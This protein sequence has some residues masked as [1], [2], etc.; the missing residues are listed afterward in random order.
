[1][2][3]AA[4]R[5]VEHMR[6]EAA[7]VSA[8]E[9]A[10]RLPVPRTADELARLATTLNSMLDRLQE[11]IERERRFVDNA[12]HELRTPLAT[13]RWSISVEGADL[14]AEGPALLVAPLRLRAPTEPVVLGAQAASRLI[15]RIGPRP[16]MSLGALVGAVGLFGLSRVT[17]HSG[18]ASGVLGPV[19]ALSF[20]LGL[21]FVS[22]TIVA[23]AGVS[24][25]ESGLSST[26]LNVGQQLG[27][28]LGIAVLGTIAATVTRNQLAIRIPTVGTIIRKS[29]AT[30]SFRALARRIQSETTSMAVCTCEAGGSEGAMRM[31]RSCGSRPWGKVAPAGVSFTPLASARRKRKVN[32]C[33][34]Q[35]AM[36][37][38]SY[39]LTIPRRQ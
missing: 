22:T 31:L 29:A 2:V 3:G 15:A 33:A 37:W 16:L 35:P 34:Y 32:F 4:L 24:P 5:P 11:A 14:L 27:G 30:V 1:V 17:D 9:P 36:E 38:R 18:Y 21:I 25:R 23:V 6:Q 12:S 13:L 19:L 20:G 28:S 26:L 10:R 7:A 8:S 39:F